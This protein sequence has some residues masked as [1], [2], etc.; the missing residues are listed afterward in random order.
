MTKKDKERARLAFLAA[1]R[2]PTLGTV[3]DEE[4]APEEAQA[5]IREV[6]TPVEARANL[7]AAH[8]A[9][10]EA[11]EAL[12]VAL[13]ASHY[14]DE[15]GRE[16]SAQRSVLRYEADAASESVVAADAEAARALEDLEAAVGVRP[17][18]VKIH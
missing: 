14:A 4:A 8:T 7:M 11:L 6:A 16:S 13:N 15:H 17:R 1:Q 9:R 2:V 3:E 10:R 5:P 18:G 12:R